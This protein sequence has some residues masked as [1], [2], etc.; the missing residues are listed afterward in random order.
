VHD[1][2]KVQLKITDAAQGAKIAEIMENCYS[3][4]VPL[5]VEWGLYTSFSKEDKLEVVE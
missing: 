3:L 5:K 4:S 2:N 1:E